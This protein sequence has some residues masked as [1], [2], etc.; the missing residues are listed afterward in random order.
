MCIKDVPLEDFNSETM[1]QSV[2]VMRLTDESPPT[3]PPRLVSFTAE[4][5]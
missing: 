2:G 3:S 5:D 1:I 4:V